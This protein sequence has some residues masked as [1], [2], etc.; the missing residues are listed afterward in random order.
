M[1][2]AVAAARAAAT[3]T[4]AGA[5]RVALRHGVLIAKDVVIFRKTGALD[6]AASATAARWTGEVALRSSSA[7]FSERILWILS[8]AV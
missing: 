6:A 2:G 8:H 1:L 4:A 5:L 3:P 7:C